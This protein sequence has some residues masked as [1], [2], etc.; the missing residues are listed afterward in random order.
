MR[1]V[2]PRRRAFVAAVV[3]ALGVVVAVALLRDADEDPRA[4]AA[5]ATARDAHDAAPAAASPAARSPAAPPAPLRYTVCLQP[6]GEHDATL[7]PPIERGIAQAYG[8]AVRRLDARPLP[9]FAWY[10]PR[11]RHRADALLGHLLYDVMPAA[12]GCHA[13]IG[14]TGL[15]VSATKGEEVDWGVL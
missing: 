4:P 10:P 5:H 13:V 3:V 8:F 7:L 2:L 15:D 9:D 12:P 1:L 11:A 14:F 6:L